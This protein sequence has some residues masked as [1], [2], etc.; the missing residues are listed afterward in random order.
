MKVRL[1]HTLEFVFVFLDSIMQISM[2]YHTESLNIAKQ[3]GDKVGEGKSYSNLGDWHHSLKRYHEAIKYHQQ[4]LDVAKQIGEKASERSAHA[5]LGLCYIALACFDKAIEH[6]EKS[7]DI[8]EQ[9]GE[10]EGKGIAYAHLAGC[11]RSK[12]EYGKAIQYLERC[13]IV[14]KQLKNRAHEGLIYNNLGMCYNSLGQYENAELNLKNSISCYGE[15][16]QSSVKKD[17]CEISIRE[18]HSCTYKPLTAAKSKGFYDCSPSSIDV[19]KGSKHMTAY[20]ERQAT[21]EKQNSY[22]EDDSRISLHGPVRELI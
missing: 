10:T 6:T 12:G 22:E 16:F 9:I 17:E 1:M 3:I 21:D 18:R 8:A 11:Y 14:A 20:A 5:N 15:I 7:L 2:R 4:H 19:E 13:L